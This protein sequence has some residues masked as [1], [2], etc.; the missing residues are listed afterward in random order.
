MVDD[1][2]S[3]NGARPAVRSVRNTSVGPKSKIAFGLLVPLVAKFVRIGRIQLIFPDN[4]SAVFGSAEGTP[5]AVKVNRPSCLLKILLQPELAVGEAFMAGDLEIDDDNLVEFLGLLLRNEE[6]LADTRLMRE[7]NRIRNAF[8]RI[9]R[10]N[11]S[12]RSRKNV[13]HHYDI[14]NDLYASFLDEEMLYSCAF[15]QDET[16]DLADAQMNKLAVSLNRLNVSPG[17]RVLDIGSG[18]G[19]VTR[20][21]ARRHA[22]AVGITLS[23]QQLELARNRA[24]EELRNRLRYE[25]CDYR[26]HALDHP[27]AYDR[28]ISIGMF[29]HV[30]RAQFGAYFQSIRRMLKRD[31]RALVHSIV[32]KKASRTNDW[33]DKYI[34]P[35]GFIPRVEDMTEAAEAAGM[36]LI[37]VPYHHASRN[38]ARTLHLWR[39]RFNAAYPTL[40]HERYDE[41]FRRMWNFYLAGSQA[42]FEALN[43]E[44]AQVVVEQDV[45]KTNRSRLQRRLPLLRGIPRRK[46]VRTDSRD[47]GRNPRPG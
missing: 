15:F 8:D 27:Q 26:D 40:D 31:G 47:Q 46:T 11:T 38:Y 28:I 39:E 44:V 35:G 42:A 32:K 41:R 1:A 17:M 4:A 20:E 6:L 5:I 18:W 16:Q 7:V 33:V 43:F 23:D 13:A 45:T 10:T 30:G 12:H 36:K 19:A 3:V 14:G 21:I 34:F 37:R 25:L 2:K 22:S 29:E 9:F 24:P